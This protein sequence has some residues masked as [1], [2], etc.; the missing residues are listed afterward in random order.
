[1]TSYK[2][3][4]LWLRRDLRVLDN[5]ALSEAVRASESVV[6]VYIA[7][8]QQWRIHGMAPIQSDLI[9][10]RVIELKKE[11]S[12]LNVHLLLLEA[13]DYEVQVS[14]LVKVVKIVG[15]EAVFA[16]REYEVNER[17]R[18]SRVETEL[19]NI[20]FHWYDS[21]CI[22]P[23][24]SVVNRQGEPYKVFTP[25]KRTWLNK[26]NEDGWTCAAIPEPI[27]EA[28][29]PDYRELDLYQLDLND[30]PYP[31]A[32]SQL[33]PI[34]TD[35]ILW[36]LYEFSRDK[37]DEYDTLRDIPAL[38]ATSGL[39]P[40]LAI[41]AL[42]PRQCL[43][44]LVSEHGA[45]LELSKGASV[46]LD[47]LIWREFYSHV[48]VA[49][50]EVVKGRAFKEKYEHIQWENDPE[51]Y[52]AWKEGNTG[53]AIVDAAMRQLNQTGW[54]HNRLRMITASFL[55][56][57]L[58]VDW[59]WGERYFMSKLVD[60]DFAS[61]NGGWQWAASTGTDAA[62]YFR[63]FNPENQSK[64]F[65]PDATFIRQ[66]IPELESA[67]ISACHRPS[68]GEYYSA[69]IVEHKARREMALSLFGSA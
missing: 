8:P 28:P 41:G 46:W 34:H 7:T 16:T 45:P 47:E 52:Q 40:Y 44:C 54:M 13:D 53:F 24:Q 22:L 49:W 15:A 35:Q 55:V 64:R 11:F 6:A 63:I 39:S 4:I 51:K 12:Q 69:A 48:I 2:S 43:T 36:R 5:P 19:T 1:M 59:R 66:Y 3:T 30:W 68:T 10:R 57:D 27:G 65:D 56:K 42:S 14:L 20:P 25:F 29:K 33:Y 18:D 32:P 62:P 61:N 26:I 38:T 67:P 21:R 58:L 37:A 31:T 23:P 17:V 50:P 9:R 60:G